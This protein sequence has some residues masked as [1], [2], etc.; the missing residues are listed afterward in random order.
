MTGCSLNHQAV[1]DG[2]TARGPPRSTYAGVTTASRSG[3]SDNSVRASLH[4]AGST[5]SRSRM[6][7]SSA[8]D[9]PSGN[10][11]NHVSSSS[12]SWAG[13]V[14]SSSR[15]T[16]NE[17]KTPAAVNT[18]APHLSTRSGAATPKGDSLRMTLASGPFGSSNSPAGYSSP[19][20]PGNARSA[21]HGMSPGRT[22][23]AA[24]RL[25]TA[26]VKT[27]SATSS[28]EAATDA[29]TA[30]STKTACGVASTAPSIVSNGW[31]ALGSTA[32]NPNDTNTSAVTSAVGNNNPRGPTT[33]RWS[34]SGTGNA[35]SA[36]RST[37]PR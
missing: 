30:G 13:P 32:R 24:T 15:T 11:D 23:A 21:S 8:T 16:A 35:P 4:R 1:Y 17:D 31:A 19:S 2:T 12:R 5:S 33:R 7:T 34:A 14:A 29:C 9:A 28:N 27:G 36:S 10:V 22:P 37:A 3:G 6:A 18:S 26:S 20:A 25:S